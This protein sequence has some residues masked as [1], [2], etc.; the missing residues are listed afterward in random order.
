MNQCRL[1]GEMESEVIVPLEEREYDH[2]K[3][4][5]RLG[6][7]WNLSDGISGLAW[8]GK[9]VEGLPFD[10][11]A[12]GVPLCE[13]GVPYNGT[14][15][16]VFQP[17]SKSRFSFN[18]TVQMIL[19]VPY[20]P[21]FGPLTQKYNRGE[22]NLQQLASFSDLIKMNSRTRMIAQVSAKGFAFEEAFGAIKAFVPQECEPFEH[23]L[24]SLEGEIQTLIGIRENIFESTKK[25][26]LEQLS[27]KLLGE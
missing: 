11:F 20:L 23:Y 10:R 8:Y 21:D 14:M 16:G 26:I 22:I 1:K 2:F 7:S 5:A 6:F 4:L 15:A 3:V 18:P 27:Q 25:V 13:I 19:R 17:R 12:V 9:D 24:S